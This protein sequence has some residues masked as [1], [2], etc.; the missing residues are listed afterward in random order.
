MK[1]INLFIAEMRRLRQCGIIPL[2][3]LCYASLTVYTVLSTVT[4]PMPRS[5]MDAVNA[6]GD[7]KGFSQTLDMSARLPLHLRA[8]NEWRW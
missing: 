1:T 5:W 2:L 3:A 6:V 4:H 7:W 8:P